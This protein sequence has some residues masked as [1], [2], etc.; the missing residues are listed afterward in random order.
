MEA[1]N[2]LPL[3]FELLGKDYVSLTS[4]SGVPLEIH[5]VTRTQTRYGEAMIMKVR[6]ADDFI[7]IITS[8]TR[9]MAAFEYFNDFPVTLTFTLKNNRWTVEA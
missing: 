9:I 5:E 4:K 1:D 7:Y 3:A 8:S 6:E 2:R